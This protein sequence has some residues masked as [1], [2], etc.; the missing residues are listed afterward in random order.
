MKVRDYDNPA[1]KYDLPAQN[2]NGKHEIAATTTITR[3]QRQRGVPRRLKISLP[4]YA[5]PE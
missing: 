1:T 3:I 4:K 5:S 2:Y